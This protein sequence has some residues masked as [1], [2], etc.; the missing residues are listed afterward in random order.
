MGTKIATV[1]FPDGT[2]MY[3]LYSTVSDYVDWMMIPASANEAKWIASTDSY[4]ELISRF[5][6][7]FFRMFGTDQKVWYTA[8]EAEV[9]A[10]IEG[11]GHDELEDVLIAVSGYFDLSWKSRASRRLSVIVGPHSADDARKSEER[12]L[13][14]RSHADGPP[15]RKR[16]F[17][18]ASKRLELLRAYISRLC[19]AESGRKP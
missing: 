7:L 18:P 10:M 13:A 19:C 1:T 5:S 14:E 4:D 6:E 3:A 8:I 9:E 12:E 2:Q 11:R 15:R 16:G 17:F